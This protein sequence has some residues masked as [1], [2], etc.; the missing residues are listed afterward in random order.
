MCWDHDNNG[1]KEKLEATIDELASEGDVCDTK[2]KE[3]VAAI[4]AN[5][6]DLA[7][8][9]KIRNDENAAFNKNDA[10]LM[11]VVK[12]IGGAI[13][14]LAAASGSASLAQIA[15]SAT[16]TNTLQSLN[17]II[18]ASA[19][20]NSDKEKLMALVQST[21]ESDEDDSELGAPAA[22]TYS[23]KSGD[24]VS[25]LEDMKDKAETQL[26]DV[27]KVFFFCES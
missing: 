6:K 2:I 8:A 15:D 4:A 1:F 13:S 22:A 16:F 19:V 18:D 26:S 23:K 17:A 25:I 21:Q 27:R 11:D 14:K 9:T 10:E 24:I 20:A 7:T 12:T 5:G 3:L